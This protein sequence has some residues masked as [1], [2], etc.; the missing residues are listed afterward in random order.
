MMLKKKAKLYLKTYSLKDTV[1]LI[2]KLEG[3]NKKKIYQICL[4]IKKKMKKIFSLVLILFF[5]VLHCSR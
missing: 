4:D 3:V 5:N 2:F 1:E